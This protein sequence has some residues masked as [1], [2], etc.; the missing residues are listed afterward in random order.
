VR[1]SGPKNCRICLGSYLDDG[2]GD[3][4]VEIPG[5]MAPEIWEVGRAHS[6]VETG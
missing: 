5:T 4:A 2:A 3:F 6:S 1:K